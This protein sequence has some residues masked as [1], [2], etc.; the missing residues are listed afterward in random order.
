MQSSE[1]KSLQV[2]LTQRQ[3]RGFSEA[4]VREVLRQVLPQ[5]AQLHNEGKSH[6]TISL[7]TL[8]QRDGK[9]AIALL[10]TTQPVS[11]AR[12]LKDIYDLGAA[13][14]ELL[15]AK[16]PNLLRNSDGSWNWEDDCAVTDQLVEV[17][18]RMVADLPQNRFN[19]TNEILS[20]LG[21]LANP[22]VG[23]PP[24]SPAPQASVKL[25]T[26]EP[27][28]TQ[29]SVQSVASPQRKPKF[30]PWQWTLIGA[31]ST[32]VSF[33]AWNMLAAPK[34]ILVNTPAKGNTKSW[35]TIQLVNT[36][37]EHS[38][39]VN[40]VAISPDGQTFVSGSSDSQIILWNLATGKSL[41]RWYGRLAWGDLDTGKR[42]DVLY[43]PR[44]SDDSSEGA[45]YSV[46]ISPDGNALV[47]ISSKQV[48]VWNF[49]TG[50]W[51]YTLDHYEVQNTNAESVNISGDSQTLAIDNEILELN[52]GKPP[53]K[54]NTDCTTSSI[55][56]LIIDS[57]GEVFDSSRRKLK[58]QQC[59]NRGNFARFIG[60]N[61]EIPNKNENKVITARCSEHFTCVQ[62]NGEGF[63][64]NGRAKFDIR[65]GYWHT[66]AFSMQKSYPPSTTTSVMSSDG[67]ILA[68]G[69]EDKEINV[70]DLQNKKI[71]R[72]LSQGKI[73]SSIA[74]S[75][76]GQM[77]AA[78]NWDK[79]I[80][81]WNLQNGKVLGTFGGWF[82][83]DG[84]SEEV[85]SVAFSP[86]GQMLASGSKD[87]TIKIW[88][89]RTGEL[90]NTFSGHTDKIKS[91]AF[92]PNGQTLVSAGA[93]KTI[94]IWQ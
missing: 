6:G 75:P 50:K 53:C 7:D 30:T 72:T 66:G 48:N 79:T 54:S 17:I 90:V 68:K 47:A 46:A 76:D 91:M 78:G 59:C 33:V 81:I 19:S 29:P 87:K 67:Q 8:V 20:A 52:T 25:P 70:L 60:P 44:P 40:S 94:K 16:A 37:S 28:R 74:I 18:N 2:L 55:N 56:Y 82:S 83:R 27:A 73:I 84:H 58:L 62:S 51:L 42:P 3:G 89:L 11:K 9:I 65:N 43:V 57:N 23:A 80:T 49:R 32:I 63:M 64:I 69:S 38:D 4:D 24:N 36:L 14:I 77:I 26:S 86:D 39:T 41:D 61:G 93:D 88:D 1:K 71:L 31:A 12:I 5:L 10:P 22:P 21:L 35:K 13:I 34:P 45:V 85:S 92:T 15:T